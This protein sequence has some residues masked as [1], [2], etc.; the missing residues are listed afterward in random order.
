MVSAQHNKIFYFI[1]YLDDMF[2]SIY[3]HLVIF[4]KLR[5]ACSL[6]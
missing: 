2:R 5:T 1:I 6:F 3:H 4:T